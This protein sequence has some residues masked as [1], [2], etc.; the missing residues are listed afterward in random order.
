MHGCPK[1]PP[2]RVSLGFPALNAARE[3]WMVVAGEDKAGAVQMA[4]QMAGSGDG[5]VQ[6]PAAGVAGTH[7][8]LWLLDEPAATA[9]PRG[10]RRR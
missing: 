9:L 8:T 6:V 2:T 10:L 1:P 3:V 5:R 4:V 7:S